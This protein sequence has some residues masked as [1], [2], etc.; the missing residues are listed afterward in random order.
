MSTKPISVGELKPG[1]YV[2]IDGIAC[3]VKS[4]QSSRPGKHG[5]AKS[6]IEAVGIIDN[7]KKIIIK[8]AH[9]TMESPIIEKEVAQVLSFS[10]E[11]A[12]VMDLKTYETFEIRIPDELKGDMKEG[13]QVTYWIILNEKIMKQ[14]RAQDE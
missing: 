8:P 6:R 11:T 10:G 9:D 1:K 12:N 3:V 13:V 4:I 7:A 14:I 2:V 5:H